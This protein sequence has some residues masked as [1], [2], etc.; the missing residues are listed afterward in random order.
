MFNYEKYRWFFTS[1]GKLVIGGKSAEQNEEIMSSVENEDVIMH[2]SSPGSPFGIIKSP[3]DEDIL[4]A[5]TFVACFSHEWKRGKTSGKKK[6]EVHIFKGEQVK[7]S[8]G[9][10]TGTFGVLGSVKRKKVDLKL[11]LDFQKGKLRALPLS[12]ARK[13]IA[14]ITPGKLDKLQATE[15][16]IK[17]IKD[18]YN[19]PITKDEVMSAIPSDGMNVSEK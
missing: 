4:E 11:A 12:V 10:K 3:T 7:K 2:T 13:R 8:N 6:V 15:K 1:S 17:I 14:I 5:A 18:K 9:M 19:Y 16:I